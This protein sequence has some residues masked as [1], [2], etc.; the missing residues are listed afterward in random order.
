MKIPETAIRH[1]R[2]VA[3]C[4]ARTRDERGDVPGWL[5]IT[6]MTIAVGMVIFGIFSDWVGPFVEDTLGQLEG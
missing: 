1:R 3:W 5:M 4:H 2:I 6:M